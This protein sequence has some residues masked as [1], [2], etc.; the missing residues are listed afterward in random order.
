MEHSLNSNWPPTDERPGDANP[1]LRLIFTG[2]MLFTYKDTADGPEA[3]VVFHRGSANHHLRILVL[4]DCRPIYAIGGRIRP[5]QIREMDLRINNADSRAVFFQGPDFNRKL[6]QGDDKDFRWLLDLE[7]PDFHNGKFQRRE[8]KFST[9]LKVRQGT[10]YT[11]KHTGHYFKCQGGTHPNQE[12]GYVP[13]VMA[14]DITLHEGDCVSLL[15]DGRE[16]LQYPLCQG[17]DYEVYFFNECESNCDN[18][19]DFP[20]TFDA[21]NIDPGEKFNLTSI[22]GADNGQAEGICIPVPLEASKLT[23]E[24]PCMGGGFGGG[25]GFP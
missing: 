21:V 1:G 2:M 13:K 11:Y 25:G 23:D 20:M 17:A 4:E 19:G 7:G 3:R 15:I 12:V 8:D 10:F 5:I 9:K 22:G 18:N 24:A 14:A 16:V 6:R